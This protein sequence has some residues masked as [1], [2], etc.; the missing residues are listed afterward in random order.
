M[1]VR[2]FHDVHGIQESDPP[3]E[4][5]WAPTNM[6]V[7]REPESAGDSKSSMTDVVLSEISNS[8]IVICDVMGG[9]RLDNLENCHVYTVC[10]HAIGAF[11]KL[12]RFR[13]HT[14]VAF[15]PGPSCWI[16]LCGPMRGMHFLCCGQA[17]AHSQ[18]GKLHVLRA[19]A[20][21]PNY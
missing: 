2:L 18:H 3:S 17:N 10:G 14:S 4:A 7:S 16:G 6:G 5:S 9:M 13:S 1:N 11:H 8:T 20:E 21:R 15:C 12:F 19:H